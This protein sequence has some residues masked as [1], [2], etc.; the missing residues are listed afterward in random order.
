MALLVG[1]ISPPLVPPVGLE[2]APSSHTTCLT[3][4]AFQTLGFKKY[5]RNIKGS[6]SNN[7]NKQYQGIVNVQLHPW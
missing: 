6:I 4:S 1:F 7:S 5:M 2:L 3:A